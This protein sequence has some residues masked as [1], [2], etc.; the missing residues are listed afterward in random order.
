[1]GRSDIKE[2]KSDNREIKTNMQDINVKINTIEVKQKEADEKNAAEFKE[3]RK[4]MVTNKESMQ[5]TI[6]ANVIAKLNP[7]KNANQDNITK[8]DVHK[9]VEEAITKLK[10]VSIPEKVGSD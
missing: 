10:P 4:E 3:I 9:I 5:E 2:I 8:D 1:M 6:T 7:I